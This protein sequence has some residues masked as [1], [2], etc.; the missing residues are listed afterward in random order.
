MKHENKVGCREL[1]NI[2]LVE[3]E[4]PI[5]IPDDWTDYVIVEHHIMFRVYLTNGEY[6]DVLYGSDTYM[7]DIFGGGLMNPP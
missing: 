1:H 6:R 2:F 4:E 7:L 3:L 5:E